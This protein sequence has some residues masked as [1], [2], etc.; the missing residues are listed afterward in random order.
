MVVDLLFI[1]IESPLRHI[2][3]SILSLH[4]SK[5]FGRGNFANQIKLALLRM[6]VKLF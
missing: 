6:F 4:L 3:S 5:E 1:C 2:N